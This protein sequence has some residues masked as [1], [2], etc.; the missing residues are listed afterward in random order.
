MA[1][2]VG[3]ERQQVELLQS[4]LC[5]AESSRRCRSQ[6]GGGGAD[7]RSDRQPAPAD[8]NS[9]HS[10]KAQTL[11][12]RLTSCPPSAAL[13]LQTD[14]GAPQ[15]PPGGQGVP[16]GP[17]EQPASLAGWWAGLNSDAVFTSTVRRGV[18]DPPAW[19]PP[20]GEHAAAAAAPG[21]ASTP[22]PPPSDGSVAFCWITVMNVLRGRRL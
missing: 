15:D 4:F 7:E 17:R 18:A 11:A 19:L 20:S 2:V 6:S 5:K 21:K 12:A 16:V 1:K 22:P 13:L 8:G 3:E 10:P 9:A 14:G